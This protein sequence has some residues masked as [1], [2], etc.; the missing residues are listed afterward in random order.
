MHTDILEHLHLA[1]S[2]PIVVQ[3]PPKP[4]EHPKAKESHNDKLAQLKAKQDALAQ[5]IKA[6]ESQ[7]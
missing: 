3:A 4:V 7:K 2:M 6:L 1:P 5:E